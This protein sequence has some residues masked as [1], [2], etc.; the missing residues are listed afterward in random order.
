MYIYRRHIYSICNHFHLA[1][2]EN[3]NTLYPHVNND[4]EYCLFEGVIS[5]YYLDSQIRDDFRCDQDCYT[6]THQHKTNY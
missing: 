1:R 4:I 2:Y 5:S 3:D 6:N